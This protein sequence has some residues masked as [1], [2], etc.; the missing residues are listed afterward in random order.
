MISKWYDDRFRLYEFA[1]DLS[2]NAMTKCKHNGQ[3]PP[4]KYI[5]QEMKLNVAFK[6]RRSKGQKINGLWLKLKFKQILSKDKPQGWDQFKCSNGWLSRWKRKYN[7]V[8]R[9]RSNKKRK[10][11]QEREP[12]LQHFHQYMHDVRNSK[13]EEHQS[14]EYGRFHPRNVY[15]FDEIPMPFVFDQESTLDY[16]GTNAVF[17]R[18]PG[19]GL[20]KRQFTTGITLRGEGPQHIKPTIIFR[21]K[22]VRIKKEEKEQWAQDVCHWF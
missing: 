9:K 2:K 19:N 13:S 6:L 8:L 22:G 10:K 1:R 12:L 16:K 17:I 15:A 21:G 3:V 18:S 5:A 14:M 11:L 4:S 20:D 7:I